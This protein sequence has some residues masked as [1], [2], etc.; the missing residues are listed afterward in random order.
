MQ[1]WHYDTDAKHKRGHFIVTKLIPTL[2]FN[3]ASKPPSRLLFTRGRNIHMQTASGGG[4]SSEMCQQR[5]RPCSLLISCPVK[6][7]TFSL[8]DGNQK[9]KPLPAF[10][11]H[12]QSADFSLSLFSDANV[13]LSFSEW[14]RW[15]S[16]SA[17]LPP[18]PPTLTWAIVLV[19]SHG[20]GT[21]VHPYSRQQRGIYHLNH[22]LCRL[23]DW[24]D[25][26]A[27]SHICRST[28]TWP[29]RQYGS[30]ILDATRQPSGSPSNMFLHVFQ[31]LGEIL[32]W[33]PPQKEL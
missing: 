26:W 23:Y 8:C 5:A 7:R 13:R 6:F 18:H 28:I 19:W 14:T 3:N 15:M 27:P 12:I 16:R 31:T 33:S 17:T 32:S 4:G 9:V 30:R 24:C 21:L 2:S 25:S 20:S 22:F 1:K 11:I 10:Q 29:W